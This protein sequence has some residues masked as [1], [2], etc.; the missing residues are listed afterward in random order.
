MT[1][2]KLAPPYHY[3]LMLTHIAMKTMGMSYMITLGD[4]ASE[5]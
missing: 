1:I 3:T 2:Q 5:N 4:L